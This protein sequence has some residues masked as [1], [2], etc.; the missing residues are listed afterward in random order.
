M[1]PTPTSSTVPTNFL[2]IQVLSTTLDLLDFK[3]WGGAQQSNKCPREGKAL[4]MTLLMCCREICYDSLYVWIKVPTMLQ[5]GKSGDYVG[6]TL[7]VTNS[8][9]FLIILWEQA[10]L[11]EVLAFLFH[12]FP[13]LSPK[14]A[15]H[16]LFVF[17][18]SDTRANCQVNS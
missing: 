16:N 11:D 1:I 12:L 15:Q 5:A 10:E 14:C 9:C 8:G 4:L 2:E 17:T 18:I 7:K 6:C 3:L 13:I